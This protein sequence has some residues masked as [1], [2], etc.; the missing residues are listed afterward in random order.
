MRDSQLEENPI[1]GTRRI[2]RIEDI[3]GQSPKN[4]RYKCFTCHKE[5]HFRR[6]CPE[7]KKN[8]FEK[9]TGNVVVVMDGYDSAEVMAISEI[10]VK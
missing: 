1:R 3:Q 6:D 7:K 5:G 9:P 2:T 8:Q 10:G 4:T